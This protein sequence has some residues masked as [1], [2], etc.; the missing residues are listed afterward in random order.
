MQNLSIDEQQ[1][2]T[3]LP[4]PHQ[5]LLAWVDEVVARVTPDRIHW[6]DGSEAEAKALSAQAIESGTL[7]PLN[8][9]LRPNSF[10]ARSDP[11]DVARVES[12]TFICSEPQS[13]AGPTNNWCAP[14]EMRARLDPL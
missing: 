4:T 12:R 6:C 2:G 13:D 14:T 1:N 10:Y 3:G 5:A 7:I 9:Q 11:R 8:P